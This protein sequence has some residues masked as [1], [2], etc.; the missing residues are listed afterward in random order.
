MISF[1][2]DNWSAS[3]RSS[4][5]FVSVAGVRLADVPVLREAATVLAERAPPDTAMPVASILVSRK[6]LHGEAPSNPNRYPSLAEARDICSATEDFA[7]PSVHYNSRSGALDL[8]DELMRLLLELPQTA[9]LQ[10]NLQHLPTVKTL[11]TLRN[12]RRNLRIVLQVNRHVLNLADWEC[13]LSSPVAARLLRAELGALLNTRKGLFSHVL[14]DLSSGLGK[15]IVPALAGAF[16][17][18]ADLFFGRGCAG[19]ALAGGLGPD[20]GDR[21]HAIFEP[22]HRPESVLLG[23]RQAHPTSLSFCAEGRLRDSNDRLDRAAMLG[24][25]GLAADVLKGVH[26]RNAR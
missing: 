16:I 1:L 26:D 13:D 6:V 11:V 5:S 4:F 9:M 24:Y 12:L 17:E 15:P 10:L 21:L 20:S 3:P 18:W 25:V 22:Y 7:W 19:A 23:A 2:P 8:N 14:F